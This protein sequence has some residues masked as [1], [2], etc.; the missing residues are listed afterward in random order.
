MINALISELETPPTLELRRF[1][2][3]RAEWKRSNYPQS[4][5]FLPSLRDKVLRQVFDFQNMLVNSP[6]LFE[7]VH[8]GKL[9]D[10]PS[11]KLYLGIKHQ[12]LQKYRSLIRRCSLMVGIVFAVTLATTCQDNTISISGIESLIRTQQYDQALSTLKPELQRNPGDYRL[13]ALEGI[14]LGLQ[15]SD[16][17]ALAAFD[18]ALNISPNYIPALKGEIEILYKSGDKRA[19][20]LLLRTLKS[21][22]DDVIAHEMLGNFDSKAGN[23]HAAVSHFARSKD[24]IANHP[25][26]L[27]A[28]GYCLFKLDREADA[29]PVFRQLVPLLPG[30]SY[31]SY[32]L[33]VLLVSVKSHDEALKV[34]EPLL[35]PDQADPD[36]LSL[37]SEVYEATGNTPK[38]VELQRQAIVFGPT[39]PSSYIRFA[40]L[41]L[42]HDSFQ[43]GI[44]M[45][46]AGL[47]R[48]PN[49]PALYLSRGVLYA[50]LAQW[51][52][53]EA[54]FK[55]S[56]QLDTSQSIGAYAGDL[57]MLQRNDPDKAL[58]RVRDQLKIHPESPL[59]HVL[60]A[61]LIMNQA[62]ESDSP[63]FKEAMQE[64][65]IA[66]K[67]KPDLVEA[68]NQLASMYMTLAQYD[69]AIRECRTALQY[70]PA[71]E[72]AMYHLIISLR[73]SGHNDELP[74]LVKRLAEMHQES[75]RHETDRKRFRLVVEGAPT[76]RTDGGR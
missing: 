52:K 49:S 67:R 20:P 44:D 10:M 19:V 45:L 7:V 71:N 15:G 74:P 36:I 73:H 43:T 35:T 24:A 21:D 54:D 46:N 4:I 63:A 72:S 41:C 55:T 76:P 40:I 22:P 11:T 13:W 57:S 50:Q 14:C 48:I 65:M 39:D 18:R 53:A 6:Y 28:Y 26:S 5:A 33:A 42:S 60:L 2:G 16:S 59:L 37:A 9:A 25:S 70:D 47:K 30:Q 32:D 17:Q 58:L 23:C 1:T 31:P 69:R 8:R 62:P 51:D 38:A 75:L 12:V 56:E 66:A 64:A 61:Q 29:I 3:P 68:H 27:E 34:L